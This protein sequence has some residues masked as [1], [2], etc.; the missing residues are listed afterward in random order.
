MR[1]TE[2]NMLINPHRPIWP[3]GGQFSNY[4]TDKV[5]GILVSWYNVY[6]LDA[7]G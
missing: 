6:R 7:G 1:D 3:Y 4:K 5:Y 2:K